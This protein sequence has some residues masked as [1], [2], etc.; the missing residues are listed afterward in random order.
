[1]V[2]A[3]D[4]APAKVLVVEDNETNVSILL[5]LLKE[6]DLMVARD[7]ATAMELIEHERPDVVLL[8]IVMPGMDGYEVCT[9][10]KADPAVADIPILFITGQTDEQS[11][12]RGFDVGASDYVTKPFRSKELLARVRIQVEYKA[13]L[14]KLRR[15]AVTDALTGVLNRRAF[16][17]EGARAIRLAGVRREPL[18]VLML[19]IDHFK[20]VNDGFGHPVGDEVLRRFARVGRECLGPRDIIGRLGGEEFAVLAQGRGDDAAFALAEELRLAVEAVRLETERGPM[21]VTVSIGVTDSSVVGDDL[22]ALLRQADAH[23][24]RAKQLGRNRVCGD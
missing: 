11:I 1:M 3:M 22:D 14:E 4:D 17:A 13:A 23:L 8:D 18:A 2:A 9:R 15:M 24:Y 16:F 12:L 19:D 20:Q 21:G 5:E 6:Y 10:L 7:G